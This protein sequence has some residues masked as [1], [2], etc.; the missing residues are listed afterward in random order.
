MS[1]WGKIKKAAGTFAGTG[2]RRF[3]KGAALLMVL[4]AAAM[5]SCGC[6]RP[7]T[8]SAQLETER[9]APRI[10]MSFDSFVIERWTQDRDVFVSTAQAMG[11]EVN[12]QNA[13]GDVQQQVE[14]IEYFIRKNMDAIVV[15]AIDGDA[16]TDVL[17]KA[18]EKGIKVICYDRIVRNANA[19]LYISFDNRQVGVLMGQA[20]TEALPDGGRIFGIYGSPTDYNVVEVVDG[21]TSTI[22]GSGL[23][24]VHTAYCDNW[25]AELAFDAVNEGLKK[26][27][28]VAGIMCG[29]DDLAS[30]TIKALSEQQLAGKVAVAGQDAELSACQR[31]MEGT[32]L[33][34]VFKPVDEEA[35]KAAIL[36]VALARGEDITV[37]RRGL[38][39]TDTISDGS[40]DIPSYLIEPR[41]VN[42]ENMDEEIIRSGFHQKEEVYLNVQGETEKNITESATE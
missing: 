16:L 29:N 40:Y 31:I 14:Q 21:F 8:E 27:P 9:K 13:N 19:D 36:T 32:Q 22:A 3:A 34:T 5:M 26:Y 41:A 7:Q 2:S 15:I 24:L 20:L 23:E 1:V 28:D 39:V 18:K 33:M 6:S 4:G 25:L 37:K 11:A 10:G 30:Q 17:A 12:V 35:E 42:R 38:P